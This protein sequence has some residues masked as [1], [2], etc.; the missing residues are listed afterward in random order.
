MI[1]QTIIWPVII[2]IGIGS[3]ALRFM[4]LGPVGRTTMPE[5]VQRHLRYTAVAILPALLVQMLKGPTAIDP[6]ARMIA[7][8]AILLTLLVS[9]VTKNLILATLAGGLVF[10]LYTQIF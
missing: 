8:S 2:A 4:F 1:D 9:Y 10:I 3:F 7:I 5:W 6:D